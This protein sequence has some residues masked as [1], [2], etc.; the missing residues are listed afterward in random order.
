MCP[1]CKTVEAADPEPALRAKVSFPAGHEPVKI[2][3]K[4]P[5]VALDAKSGQRVF[6]P[7]RSAFKTK[8]NS[9]DI[10]LKMR[11]GILRAVGGEHS[12]VEN[13]TR[14]VGSIPNVFIVVVPRGERA[15]PGDVILLH[16]DD[17]RMDTRALVVAGGTEEAPMARE[18]TTWSA[19][20]PKPVRAGTFIVLR[21]WAAGTHLVCDSEGEL[22]D[23]VALRV[24]G[25]QVVGL[26]WAGKL[27][28]DDKAK[29]APVPVHPKLTVGQQVHIAVVDDFHP[30]TV[31]AIDEDAGFAEVTFQ[32]GGSPSDRKVAFGEI[33]TALPK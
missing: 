6:A 21:P 24:I 2:A 7:Y 3:V 1:E 32:W 29:C 9:F 25:E 10:D 22:N 16:D 30:A 8:P 5:V 23:V 18:M 14:A 26:G 31:Q 33:L 27:R 12:L 17:G 28:F 4:V 13:D 20:D 11:T 19:R 15:S